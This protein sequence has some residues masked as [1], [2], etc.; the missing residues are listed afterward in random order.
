MPS[1]RFARGEGIRGVAFPIT[2]GREGYWPRRNAAAI[3]QSSVLMIL[4][5]V[6]GERLMMPTFGS[7]LPFLLFEPNDVFLVQQLKEETAAALATWDPNLDVVGIAPEMAGD[8]IQVFI[9]YIDRRDP[10][11]ET[12]RAVFNVLRS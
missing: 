1:S 3:R 9:D 7:R 6:P 10:N 11:P 2:K 5:T 4:G 8:V 12:R